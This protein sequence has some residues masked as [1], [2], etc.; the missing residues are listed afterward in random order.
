M[1]NIFRYDKPHESELIALLK[2]EP[3]WNSFTGPDSINAFKNALLTSE[4]YVYKIES[5]ICGYLRA[6]VDE[7]GIYVSEL[8][9]SP[10]HRKNGY[11]K[12]LLKMIKQKHP[13]QEVY[14]LSDEDPYYERLGYKRVGSIFQL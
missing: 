9:I 2:S 14:V 3:D 1:C 8:Y 11:G 13:N 12:E 6:L 10:S 7:F 5:K 4:T